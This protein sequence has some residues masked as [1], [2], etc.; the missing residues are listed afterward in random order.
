MKKIKKLVK[1][2]ES[3][4]FCV[5]KHMCPDVLLAPLNIPN[6]CLTDFLNKACIPEFHFAYN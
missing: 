1:S 4:K 6:W 2:I 3:M 5:F